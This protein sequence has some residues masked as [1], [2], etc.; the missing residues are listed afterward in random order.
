MFIS[1]YFY[2][3]RQVTQAHLASRVMAMASTDDWRDDSEAE[4]QEKEE[5]D[6]FAKLLEDDLFP[7]EGFEDADI[8]KGAEQKPLPPADSG[9]SESLQVDNARLR[10]YG[11]KVTTAPTTLQYHVFSPGSNSSGHQQDV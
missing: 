5:D 3:R 7:D 4:E 1:L 9:E 6:E 2:A 8:G 10:N 11:D